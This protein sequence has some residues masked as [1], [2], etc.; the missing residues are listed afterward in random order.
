[1]N[2]PATCLCTEVEAPCYIRIK[3]YTPMLRI[4]NTV[5]APLTT[6]ALEG[7]LL[8]P[9]ITEVRHSIDAA[10]ALGPVRMNLAQ[11]QFADES[12]VILL[13]SLQD[14]QI[15]LL[16]VSPLI[17]ALLHRSAETQSV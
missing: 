2:W 1:M 11:L 7:K 6:I 5:S 8:Q 3:A 4:I 9:W 16:D 17:T 10:R 12:G 15:P 14:Q 13:Q